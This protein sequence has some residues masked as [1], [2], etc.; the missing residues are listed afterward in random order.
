MMNTFIRVIC[1]TILLSAFSFRAAAEDFTNAIH[2]FLQHRVEAEKING[3]IVVGILDEHGSS[4]VSYGKLD[5]G[6]DQ[7]VNGDTLFNIYSGS[8]VFTGLLLQDMIGRGEMKLDDPVAKYLPKT[9]KMPTYNGKEITLRHLLTE[10]TGFPFMTENLEYFEPKR[11]DNP[12]ADFTVEKMYAFVSSYRLTCDPGSVHQ[13]GSVDM[14]LL[15][16]AIALKAGTNYES[17]LAERICRPLKMDCTQGTLTPELKSRLAAAHPEQFGY[18]MPP[19]EMGAL[20]PLCGL[21]S[22]AND[23]LKFVSANLGLT[24]S[25]LPQLME[26]Y[27]AHFPVSPDREKG[28]IHFGGGNPFVSHYTT[29]D[30]TRRRGVV[31]LASSGNG[32]YRASSIGRYLLESEWQSDRRPNVTNL[33]SQVYG[34]YAGQYQRSPDFALGMF[35]MRQCFLSAPKVAIYVPVGFGLAVL[36]GLLWRAGSSRKRWSLLGCVVLAGGVLV[37]L[38]PLV[39]SH[40]FCARF[41]PRIGICAEGGRFFTQGSATGLWPIEDWDHAPAGAH[42]IDELLPPLPLELMP[43]SETRFFERLSGMPLTFTRDNRG[44]VTG[45]TVY[46]QGKA[47]SYEKISDQPP[48]LPEP[49]KRPVGI[50]L[51]TRLLDACVG[52][53]EQTP[54]AAFPAGVKAMIWRE[55]DQ[56]VWRSSGKN[57]PKGAIE[58]YPQSETNFFDKFDGTMTFVKNDNGEVTVVI[59]RHEEHP[60]I[61]G[62]KVKNE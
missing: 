7:E 19:M 56:L 38:A 14:G 16:Q 37:V 58:I 24:P 22:T 55:E 25:S 11:A 21:S 26:K 48:Q 31:V 40:E 59:F 32:L 46:D 8:C 20:T 12:F 9:V 1:F 47:F 34:L 5:N 39:W 15:G 43:Q 29:F 33:S 50:K 28:I 54:C 27:L 61:D 52:H 42:P 6:T 18:A 45:L 35:S 57:A 3:C 53:Y 10:T 23:L 2:A 36:L 41:Q 62:K 51:D 13:H 49:P 60:D 44:Q 30:K 17:F 4:I